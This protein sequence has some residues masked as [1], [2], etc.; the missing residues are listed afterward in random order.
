M[1]LLW[2]LAAA[3]VSGASGLPA[4]LSGRASD[5]GQLLAA[6]LSVAGSAQISPRG[7]P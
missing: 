5:R 4:L 6:F 1:S 3:A 2:I 7:A